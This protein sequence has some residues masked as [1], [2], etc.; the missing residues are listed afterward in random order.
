LTASANA[1]ETAGRKAA[2]A[3]AKAPAGLADDIRV[4]VDQADDLFRQTVLLRERA[5]VEKSRPVSDE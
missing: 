3:A 1:F 5:T 2:A 4:V